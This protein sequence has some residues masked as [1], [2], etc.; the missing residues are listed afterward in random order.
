MR[1]C[2]IYTDEDFPAF[3]YKSGTVYNEENEDFGGYV[4]VQVSDYFRACSNVTHHTI[5]GLSVHLH[6]LAC[7]FL[8]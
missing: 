2:Y 5:S 3:I 4:L 6:C 1:F 8:S 7:N